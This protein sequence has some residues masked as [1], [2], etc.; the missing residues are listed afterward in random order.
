MTESKLEEFQEIGHCGGKFTIN[1]STEGGRR[2]IQFGLIHDRPNAAAFFAVA[3][4]KFT[5]IVAS[6]NQGMF[7]RSCSKCGEYWRSKA[8]PS[9][10]GMTCPYCGFR[11][12]NP[13]FLTE[14]QK[15][16]VEECLNRIKAAIKS[17]EDGEYVV[18]MDKVA[19]LVGKE[20]P[21]P[22]FYY[23]EK[24]Q[25]NL[26]ECS[27]C[28]NYDDILGRYGYCSCCGTC[29][30][31]QELK[32]EILKIEN[33]I[34]TSTED[35]KCLKDLISAFDGFGRYYV[36][37]LIKHFPL[38]KK[39]KKEWEWK[40][41]HN[42]KARA[43]EFLSVMGIDLFKGIESEDTEFADKM[44]CRRHVYEHNGGVV[45]QQYIDDSGDTS[46]RVGQ[47]IRETKE[48]TSRLT[49]ILSKIGF[50][51]HEGLLKLNPPESKALQYFSSCK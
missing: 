49:K 31:F 25:Q 19:D 29:N 5:I 35:D 46:V 32:Q 27:A 7:G 30:G 26:Y 34:Q 21:K 12:R 10:W 24:K 43:A 40:K 15:R 33:E 20:C 1:I 45:D 51:I 3:I 39:K 9:E 37:Q 16:Y 50:N 28:G 38:S 18:D 41:I 17:G 42:L 6:D 11:S 22:K 4:D 44:F 48:S 36:K 2:G 13:D 14:G 47:R 23:S 8:A